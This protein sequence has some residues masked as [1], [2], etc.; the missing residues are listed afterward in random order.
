MIINPFKTYSALQQSEKTHKLHNLSGFEQFSVYNKLPSSLTNHLKFLTQKDVK[1]VKSCHQL[2]IVV[3]KRSFYT[4]LCPP[5]RFIS[6]DHL[7]SSNYLPP[8][9]SRTAICHI[10]KGLQYLLTAYSYK[11]LI[12]IK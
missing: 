2:Y 1:S 8:R 9:L 4:L 11:S 12:T 7:R 5:T 6:R 3:L 10:C